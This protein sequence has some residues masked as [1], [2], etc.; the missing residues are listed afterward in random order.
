MRRAG[1]RKL[2]GEML[3][4]K[5]LIT[6][7]Q[8]EEGLAAQKDTTDMRIG[9]VLVNLGHVEEDQ[10]YATLA[11]QQNVRYV[12]LQRFGVDMN[13]A[14]LLDKTTA[15]RYRAVPI[16]RG[17]G[18]IQVAMA[19]PED[20]I[21][22]DDLRMRLQ[23]PVEAVLATPESIEVTIERAHAWRAGSTWTP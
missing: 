8:L 3:I 4:A 22:L 6:P 23:V 16:A 17:D 2:I 12:S 5:G 7:K 14:A 1:G 19:D 21:A 15:Q 11:E 13:V 20:V 9:A 10:L 18:N